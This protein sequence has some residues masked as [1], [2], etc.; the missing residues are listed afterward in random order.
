MPHLRKDSTSATDEAR[1]RSFVAA[2]LQIRQESSPVFLERLVEQRFF[3]AV[4][5]E[6][7]RFDLPVRRIR[8]VRAR[9]HP[10]SS[11]PPETGLPNHRPSGDP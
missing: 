10:V 4:P 2:R 6:R 8:W 1:E 5:L 7:T 9:L 11:V 3:G